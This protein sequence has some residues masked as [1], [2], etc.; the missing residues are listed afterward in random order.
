MFNSIAITKMQSVILAVIIVV[1]AVAGSLAYVL[2]SNP[3][4]S[5]TIK[6]GVF[7]DLDMTLGE[8]AW[9]GTV[10]AAEEINAEGGILGRQ[11]EVVGEDNDDMSSRDTLTYNSALN[12]LLSYHKVDFLVGGGDEVYEIIA[13]HKKI[14]LAGTGIND[15]ELRVLDDYERYKYLFGFG[16]NST[17]NFQ[18]ITDS[19]KTLSENT[20]FAKVAY[21]AE[22][23]EWTKL[24]MGGLD[25]LL[26][27]V[28]GYEIVYKGVYP[29]ET[30]DFTS[31][32]AQAEAAGA[33]VLIPLCG[34][35]AWIPM[36]KEWYDRQSPMVIF[37]GVM[38]GVG[39][40]ESWE[41]TEGKCEA[42]S[43]SAGP[44]TAAYPFTSKTL[45]FRD[46]YI[47]RWGESPGIAAANAYDIVR[48]IL[49][50]AIERAKTI[51]TDSVVEAL[52][53]V[54]VETTQAR[55]FAFSSSHGIMVGENPNDPDSDY[56]VV[57]VFQWQNGTL[58]PVHPQK[59]M[60]EAGASLI[61]PDW[62]GPWDE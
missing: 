12:R 15:I 50:D 32:F 61:F 7:A 53:Q 57:L 25:N 29:T 54:N 62:S 59:I 27:A 22:D 42:I 17:S 35:P 26:P 31:Y 33:E 18:G 23:G 13:E 30:V 48:F 46:A 5:G 8:A 6:I 4:A 47:D 43:S 19:F 41:L 9:R 11:I 28:Y 56:M 34:G 40:P 55:N 51:E 10:L 21:L 2:L 52:E 16:W 36:V 60:E 14:L 38:G 24:I 45:P 37:S 44:V 20:D 39:L 49:Y 58:V 1:A 3:G